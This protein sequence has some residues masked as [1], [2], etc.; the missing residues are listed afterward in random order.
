MTDIFISY[1]KADHTLALKLSAFL[2]AEGWSVWWDRNLSAGEVYRDEIM[3]EL[4]AARAV[5]VIWTQ[6][7][8]K[9]DWARA[10]AG[11]AKAEGKL[12]PVKA[13][14]L[15]YSDIPLPF[16]EMH[17]ENLTATDLIRAAIIAQLSKP[18]VA[19]SPMWLVTKTIRLQVLTWAGII[20][21]AFTIF[22]SLRGLLNL[23]DWTRWMVT[24]WHEWTQ[25]FWTAALSW[26]GLHVHPVFAPPLSF[27]MF[28]V[29]VV[30]GTVLRTE[31]PA[32][33]EGPSRATRS[34]AQALKSMAGRLGI[35]VIGCVVFFGVALA[36]ALYHAGSA[37]MA[38][39]L[40][41]FAV[42][43]LAPIIWASQERLQ[44]LALAALLT[45]FWIALAVVPLVSIAAET[46]DAG[47][48][49]LGWAGIFS[50]MLVPVAVIAI[51]SLAPVK[52]INQR[53][54]FLA[55][56][57]LLLVALNA[58]SRLGLHHLLETASSPV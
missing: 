58:I 22:S 11:H 29:M 18:A 2:E 8:V 55:T 36:A 28:L 3:R 50:A 9:S 4:S 23:A 39:L 53:L 33:P 54:L 15:T 10:E 16:G 41:A 5:V 27:T 20:G 49:A 37:Y 25:A 48:L 1:S 42:V 38:A 40:G 12:I 45:L 46:S 14:G 56:G 31:T 30:V 43:P 34:K 47:R 52:S 44:S 13:P 32:F 24:H 26:I 17:T 21:G 19:A 35:Y 6:T 51:E 7:S 57:A